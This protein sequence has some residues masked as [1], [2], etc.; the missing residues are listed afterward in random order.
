MGGKGSGGSR[1]NSGPK[2][3]P[4]KVRAFRVPAKYLKECTDEMRETLKKYR[5]K[6][7]M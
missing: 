6:C 3:V 1:K 7:K 5:L 4:Y 2:A